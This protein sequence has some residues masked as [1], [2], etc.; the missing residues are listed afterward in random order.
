MTPR[1]WFVIG[2]LFIV[3]TAGLALAGGVLVLNAL[4]GGYQAYPAPQ[5]ILGP[6][7]T[8]FSLILGVVLAVLAGVTFF[9]GIACFFWGAMLD[10]R[11][12]MTQILQSLA[13]L[14]GGRSHDR[15]D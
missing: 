1:H 14:S 5:I 11:Q 4:S 12:Q 13:G 2:W 8:P 10:S 9:S 15:A 3:A 7:H 6:T